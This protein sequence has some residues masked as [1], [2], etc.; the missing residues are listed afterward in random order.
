MISHT[1]CRDSCCGLCAAHHRRM[2]KR[3]RSAFLL[4]LPLISTLARR[5]VG[6][7]TMM[8][9]TS[10]P[11]KIAS[12]IPFSDDVHMHGER[13]LWV[14]SWEEGATV[15]LGLGCVRGDRH[16]DDQGARAQVP[17]MAVSPLDRSVDKS[18]L[19]CRPW[20]PP[21]SSQCSEKTVKYPEPPL[22]H[23]QP[24]TQRVARPLTSSPR[25]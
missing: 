17:L 13:P 9:S 18:G 3:G 19:W 20:P 8:S 16:R 14:L 6:I 25:R 15:M 21:S 4:G 12:I 22:P 7:I 11:K 5:R 2:A 23:G 1:C 10:T 24:S